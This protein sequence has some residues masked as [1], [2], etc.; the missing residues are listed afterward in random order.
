MILI[1]ITFLYVNKLGISYSRLIPSI[2]PGL[3]VKRKSFVAGVL[4]P[5]VPPDSFNVV[6]SSRSLL[7]IV[8]VV[9]GAFMRTISRVKWSLIESSSVK[10]A[11][12]RAA[13]Q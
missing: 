3:L 12:T 8:D 5:V 10:D 4:P 6:N 13:I 7:V 11:R 1:L 9:C 2:R